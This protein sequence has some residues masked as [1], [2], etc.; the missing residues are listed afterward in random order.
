MLN[1]FIIFLLLISAVCLPADFLNYFKEYSYKLY[2]NDKKL[3]LKRST[4]NKWYLITDIYYQLY[5]HRLGADI[6]I[7]QV[8]NEID[9]VVDS[10]EDGIVKEITGYEKEL[11][12]S[13]MYGIKCYISSTDISIG[14]LSDLRKSYKLS[15]KIKNKSKKIESSFGSALTNLVVATYFENSFWI[16]D[17]FGYEG[18]ILE[19]VQNLKKISGEDNLFKI[20]SSLALVEFYSKLLYDHRSSIEYT[21]DLNQN[22]PESK[23]F[24]FLY[25]KDLYQTGEIETAYRM[26]KNVNSDISKNYYPYEYSSLIYEIKCLYLL[27][28]DYL[29]IDLINY[30]KR[31]HDGYLLKQLDKWKS[32]LK[33]RKKII[34]QFE[35]L[36]FRDI[37]DIS[38][39]EHDKKITSHVLFDHGYFKELV[40][41]VNYKE[42]PELLLLYFRAALIL[43]EH[44][45]A[46]ELFEILESKHEDFLD[47][48]PDNGRIIILKNILDNRFE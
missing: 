11:I 13:M 38:K 28:K 44:R 10:I 20:E 9:E 6:N 45:T 40:S 47:D 24:K 17:V 8:E 31:I 2:N 15:E 34:Y 39:N 12:I 30:T 16:K 48:H 36:N 5:K 42:E 4:D 22:Y 37:K 18:D 1:K 43:G 46:N 35:E 3:Y 27:D 23:Y 19:S 7:D 14:N 32:S 29:V 41:L 33:R 26:F 25:A 21:K